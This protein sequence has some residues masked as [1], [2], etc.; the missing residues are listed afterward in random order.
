MGRFEGG[1][2]AILPIPALLQAR[3]RPF[4]AEPS[5]RQGEVAARKGTMPLWLRLEFAMWAV[6]A[7]L[8]SLSL[9]LS[10]VAS[11]ETIPPAADVVQED[12]RV[13]E[14]AQQL[15]SLRAEVEAELA[16]LAERPSLPLAEERRSVL[17]AF[18][19][20][21]EVSALRAARPAHALL[22]PE[23][24]IPPLVEDAPV[25][26]AGLDVWRDERDGLAFQAEAL[27]AARQS[28][29]EQGRRDHDQIGAHRS[30]ERLWKERVQLAT[31]GGRATADAEA[32]SALAYW[33]ARQAEFLWGE[34]QA[35]GRAVD[36]TLPRIESRLDAL[37]RYIHA[38]IPRQRLDD[39]ALEAI[40]TDIEATAGE[41][42]AGIARLRA[43][44]GDPDVAAAI[45]A[46]KER[47]A[48]IRGQQDVWRLRA[49]VLQATAVGASVDA[50]LPILDGAAQQL[51]S[52]RRWAEG[53]RA[54]AGARSD[55]E[56][57]TQSRARLLQAVNR[58]LLLI[59]RTRADVEAIESARSSATPGY[60]LVAGIR[61]VLRSLWEWELFAVTER[62][63]VDGREVVQ[64]YG[65][66]LGKSIGVLLLTLLG[67]LCVSGLTRL[68]RSRLL[69]AWGL[70]G[71]RARTVTRWISGL[72]F[73]LVVLVV[74][75]LARIP[76]VA[77]AFLGG[78]LAIGIGFGAQTLLKNVM[79]GALLLIERRV[80]IGDVITVAGASG[81]C[82]DIGLRSTTIAG[83]DGIEV[84]VPNAALLESI[85]N[86]WTGTSTLVRRELALVVPC[87]GRE[88]ESAGVVEACA[89]RTVGVLETPAPKVLASGFV[90]GGL[91][92]TL[93]FW[94]SIGASPP[95]PDIESALRFEISRELY[96]RDI[97]VLPPLRVA[98]V[99]WQAKEIAAAIGA[100]P[101]ATLTDP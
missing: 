61:G 66:T 27:R 32:R 97:A 47:I 63:V 77:F 76:L 89:R 33:R 99:P 84:I 35:A 20:A 54:F 10:T 73:L 22:I 18:L 40:A 85:V 24:P 81:T 46:E 45:A 98:L 70:D 12:L 94:V 49:R 88:L 90:D 16:R 64:E 31:A 75:K 3:T 1:D 41:A 72:M 29:L 36:A 74:L 9:A 53:Q 48:V 92:L 59:E 23:H 50:L 39:S 58:S 7:S 30:E 67:Y 86:N 4:W 95:S 21:I 96:D 38:A 14:R 68:L 91:Q 5:T 87:D 78:A 34:S 100:T 79:S 56:F 62:H 25:D 82:T 8:F 93:Q 17:I 11:G 26:T 71:Q 6:V 51:E 57:E 42:E 52:R 69:P 44:A 55:G 80:R 101:A 28:L 13:P 83:F 37:D 19:G 65:V 15:D 60:A 2:P 43:Q